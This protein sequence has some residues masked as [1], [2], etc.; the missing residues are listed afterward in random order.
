MTVLLTALAIWEASSRPWYRLRVDLTTQRVRATSATNQTESPPATPRRARE[1]RGSI[2][3]DVLAW[4]AAIQVSPA[5]SPSATARPARTTFC[6]SRAEVNLTSSW[7]PGRLPTT[8]A[9]PSE[10]WPAR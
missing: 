1:R 7:R 9:S 10:I 5:P 2:W 8:V 6:S 4:V 3:S